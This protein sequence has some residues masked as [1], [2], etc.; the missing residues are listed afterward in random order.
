MEDYRCGCADEMCEGLPQVAGEDNMRRWVVYEVPLETLA[1]MQA[2]QAQ[3]KKRAP[4]GSRKRPK[5]PK[6]EL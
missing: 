3:Q 2:Q 6:S 5:K 1:A 4:A